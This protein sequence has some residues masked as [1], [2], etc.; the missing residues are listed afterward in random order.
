MA[1][2]VML[3]LM[4]LTFADV[5]L[6]DV[7]SRPIRGGLEITEMML[8]AVIFLGLPLTT[9]ASEHVTLDTLDEILPI[10]A[11]TALDVLAQ[12][13]CAAMLFGASWLIAK[14]ALR[15]ADDNDVS[16]QLLLPLWPIVA[17]I[18]VALAI[19]AVLHLVMAVQVVHSSATDGAELGSKTPAGES[20]PESVL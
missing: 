12:I 5:I 8:A 2:V 9:A 6:R 16:S 3:A 15:L 20:Q 10:W 11:R 18:A 4:G 1:V 14:R 7:F 17:L 13:V 19:S